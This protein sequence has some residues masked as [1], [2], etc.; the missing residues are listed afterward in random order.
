MRTEACQAFTKGMSGAHE[1]RRGLVV[2]SE[3]DARSA[4]KSNVSNSTMLTHSWRSGVADRR[5][6]P[7]GDYAGGSDDGTAIADR[8][9]TGKRAR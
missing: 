6:I 1:H 9:S 8:S 4:Q 2:Q 3:R 7:L 5:G